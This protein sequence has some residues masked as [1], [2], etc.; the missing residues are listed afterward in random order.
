MYRQDKTR[1]ELE[2]TTDV[3][4]VS[5]CGALF[6]VVFSSFSFVCVPNETFLNTMADLF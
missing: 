3:N 6:V 4:F 5:I 1:Q 2:T